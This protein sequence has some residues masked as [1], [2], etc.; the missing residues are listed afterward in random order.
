MG[1]HFDAKPATGPNG[2]ELRGFAR[3]PPSLPDAAV[4]YSIEAQLS[5]FP[6][7]GSVCRMGGKSPESAHSVEKLRYLKTGIFRQNHM[8]RE[9]RMGLLLRRRA[10]AQERR[11][12]HLAKPLAKTN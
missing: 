5:A 6:R 9:S 11:Q 2:R 8:A 10:P 1:R 12:A 4:R 7:R 3:Y